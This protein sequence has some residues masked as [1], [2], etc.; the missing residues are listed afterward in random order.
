LIQLILSIQNSV[1]NYALLAVPLFVLMGETMFHS[2]VAPRMMQV[3]EKWL[4][5]IPGRLSLLAVAG[6]TIFASVSGAAVAGVAMLGSVLVP[7][8]EKRGYKKPMS[9]GPILGSG[10]LAVMIPPSA[11]G[12]LMAALGRF[13]VGKFLIAILLPGLL[14]AILYAGYIIVRCWLQ[15]ELAPSYSIDR[16][17]WSEKIREGVVFIL[18]IS[19]IIFLVVGFI[20]LG[21][22]SP[23]EA[24]ATG[25]MGCFLLAFAYMRKGK[26]LL[27]KRASLGAA[28]VTVMLFMIFTGSSAFSQILAYTG[29]T[30][31]LVS[32]AVDLPFHPL[33]SVM[34]MQV[35]L[36]VLGMFME[37]LSIMMITLPVFI[38]IVQSHNYDLLWFGTIML[39]N[40]EMAATSPPFGTALFVMKSVA[41]EGTTMADIYWAAIPFL[42]CDLAAM[43]L[44]MLFPNIVLWLP[45]LMN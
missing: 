14:M 37:P 7:E 35:V 34:L 36:L 13:S 27:I 6:G 15:P 38:P 39:L 4:G 9:L 8:M 22:A 16:I 31:G 29:A 21:V 3:L 19:I 33:M 23:T 26:C 30:R 40:M 24:S 32:L 10:G 25:A 17:P 2:G 12:V 44:I 43:G 42:I 5:R 41:P 11:L 1:T 45:S 28:K 18:P 20:F